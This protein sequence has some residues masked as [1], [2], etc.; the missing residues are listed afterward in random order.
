MSKL[1]MPLSALIVK[2]VRSAL[3]GRVTAITYDVMSRRD[4]D[5]ES[6][7]VIGSTTPVDATS[8]IVQTRV[9]FVPPTS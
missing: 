8:C 4:I 2:K 1:A 3:D 9:V 5:E 7:I 6:G